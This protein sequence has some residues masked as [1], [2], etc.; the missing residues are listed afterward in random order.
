M[1]FC[2]GASM[3]GSFGTL[4]HFNTL[5][6]NVPIVLCPICHRM[7][8][9]PAIE[10]EYEILVEYA[11][12]DQAPEV[13]FKDFVTVDPHMFENCTMTDGGSF[14]DVLKQQIDIAL[15]LLGAATQ[16]H[17]EEWRLELKKRL[18]TLSE[19]LRNHQKRSQ[20]RSKS[21]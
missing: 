17:D 16:L 15:D 14:E 9:H 7:E 4:R 8:V 13:D 2:C 6:H 10:A 5:I 1:S 21:T 19:R 3:I 11:N 12:G 20:H 18:Q